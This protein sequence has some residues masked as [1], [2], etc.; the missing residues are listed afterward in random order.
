MNRFF[1]ILVNCCRII[2]FFFLLVCFGVAGKRQSYLLTA[3]TVK[4]IDNLLD[5][6]IGTPSPHTL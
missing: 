4:S 5:M 6:L 3:F 1:I 2:V